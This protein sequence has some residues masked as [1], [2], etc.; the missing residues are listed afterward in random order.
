M[1]SQRRPMTARTA[2]S[3]AVLLLFGVLAAAFVSRN[4]SR[5]DFIIRQQ[6]GDFDIDG[7]ELNPPN[8][9]GPEVNGPEIQGPNV[10]GPSVEWFDIFYTILLT[11][12]IIALIAGLILIVRR[13][14]PGSSGDDVDA[15][16]TRI[17]GPRHDS[18]RS[19]GEEGWAAFERFC[20]ALLRDPDP[21]RAVRVVMRYAE[22]GMGRLASRL[23]DETSNEWLRR[24][25]ASD[26][27]LAGDLGAIVT[28]Y[29]SVRF[30]GSGA[31]PAERDEAVNALRRL[32]R[33]ACG[34]APPATPDQ[35]TASGGTR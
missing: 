11:L 31:S 25:R 22:S 27:D 10:N 35:T 17:A 3:L 16:T 8:F 29:Q 21:S 19:G 23:A 33:A 28:N 1:V 5:N 14:G 13:F 15:R 32:A 6:V 9:D 7:P 12:S 24:I 30:G 34:T 4:E 26:S 2:Y 18:A 20:Y